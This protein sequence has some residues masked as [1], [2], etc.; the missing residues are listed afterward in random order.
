MTPRAVIS[1]ILAWVVPGAGHFYLGRRGRAVAF[2]GIVVVMFVLGILLDGA[3]YTR[4]SSQGSWLKIL[5]SMA[6]L[7]AGLLYV[8]AAKFGAL[9][10]VVS[11]TY[12]YGSAFMLTAGLMNLLLVLD[13]YDIECGRKAGPQVESEPEPESA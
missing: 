2:F 11:A 8:C 12:E 5:A 6:S 9:G 10:D 1:M 3:A 7:G 4:A 13:C